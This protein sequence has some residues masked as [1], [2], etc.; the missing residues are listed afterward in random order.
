MMI[1]YRVS[2]VAKDLNIPSKDIIALLAQ[3]FDTP[4]KTATVLEEA[5][6]DVIFEYYTQGNK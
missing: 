6:L 4:K 3:Y 2:D 5:E 1:K